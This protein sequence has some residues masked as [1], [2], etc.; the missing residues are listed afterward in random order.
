MLTRAG[1]PAVQQAPPR[2]GNERFLRPAVSGMPIALF[3]V[4]HANRFPTLQDGQL[5]QKNPAT[6]RAQIA[7]AWVNCLV[8]PPVEPD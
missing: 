2:P 1:L 4:T 3:F 5:Y 7:G 6:C 8:A